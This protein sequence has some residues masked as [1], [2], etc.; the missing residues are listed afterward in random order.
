[1]NKITYLGTS[2]DDQLIRSVDGYIGDALASEKLAVDTIDAVVIDKS[3]EPRLLV[4]DGYLAVANDRLAVAQTDSTGLDVRS[5]YGETVRYYRDDTL[6]GKFYLAEKIKRT[7]KYEYSMSCVSAVGLL[8]TENHY[9]GIYNGESAATVI[10]D[11]VGGTISYTIDPTLAVVP[12]Y[13]WL[14]KS[15]RRDN[16]RDVLFAI[17]G[18]IRKDTVGELNIVPMEAGETYEITAD[19]F[20]IGG[21]VT[22][23]NP[24][25]GIDVTEHSFMSLPTDAEETLYDGDSADEYITTP[26]KKRVIGVLVD[27]S[28]PMHDLSVENAEILESGAN[29]AVISG[30]PN[31]VLK[32]KKYTHTQRVIS[33]RNNTGGAPNVLVSSGCTIV[34]LLNAESVADRLLAYYG[35]GKTVEADIVVTNQ[36][37]GDSVV[38]TDPFGDAAAGFI[39]D[40]DLTMSAI[41]KA[42]VNI[43]SGYVPSEAGNY[44]E[45]LDVITTS[46]TYT[47]Q[48]SCK[49]KIRAVLIGAGDGGTAGQAGENGSAGSRT[50][51]GASGK[52]GLPGTAGLGGKIFVVT[53]SVRVGQTFPVRLGAAGVGAVFGGDPATAGGDTTF[54]DYSSANGF[55]SDTGYYGL[56]D[57]ITYALSGEDG[58]GGGDGQAQDGTQPTVTYKGQTWTAG[59]R[60]AYASYENLVGEVL[61]EAGG[62]AG[63]GAAVGVDGADG[64][65]GTA[66]L[67]TNGTTVANGGRGADGATPIAGE[68]GATFGSGGSGGHGGGGG[69][70][71]GGAGAAVGDTSW[72]YDIG[73]GGNGS[74]GGNG[75]PGAV[76]IYY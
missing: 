69:G 36:R 76:L 75:A 4:A 49:G 67:Q 51:N 10:A 23:G 3:L 13:G 72:F 27:F 32:G 41:L 11:V 1:M 28:E 31:A 65:D 21:S 56:I 34:S 7:G 45:S 14:K 37:P 2:Y 24:A 22:G 54:G 58:I 29:Y 59:N 63:G 18:Q 73:S 25:T 60:G 47:V 68:N 70:G 61:A 50:A 30:S 35:Y 26:K 8:L 16:L 20:Y 43:V 38:F 5:R 62:G 9:G 57:G 15:T 33:R 46:G 17:G 48:K 40:M 12:I 74:N 52:G 44:Y 39:A 42:R 6:F 55:R 71:A 19:E 64:G 66:Y 53:L